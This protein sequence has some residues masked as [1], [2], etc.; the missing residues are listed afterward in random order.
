MNPYNV[1]RIVYVSVLIPIF[2]TQPPVVP[3]RGPENSPLDNVHYDDLA[4]KKCKSGGSVGS[5][6]SAELHN[7]WNSWTIHG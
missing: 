1:T 7:A 2:L 4:L 3:E 6:D 5:L